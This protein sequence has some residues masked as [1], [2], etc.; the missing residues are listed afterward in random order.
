VT[1]LQRTIRRWCERLLDRW[2]EGPD[3]PDRLLEEVGHFREML[4]GATPLQWEVFTQ[5]LTAAAYREGY[6]R[7][8]EA[9]ER[10]FDRPWRHSASPEFIAD[11]ESP[12][13]RD[14]PRLGD[15]G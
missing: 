2:Q 12:G 14:S 9:S 10:G 15:L 13:W 7:G 3:V 5:G 6:L 8:F 1:L 11:L 4:P